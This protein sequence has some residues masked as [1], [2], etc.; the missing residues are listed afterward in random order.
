MDSKIWKLGAGAVDKAIQEVKSISEAIDDLAKVQDKAILATFGIQPTNESDSSESEGEDMPVE[1]HSELV[2]GGKNRVHLDDLV[3][4]MQ[5]SSFNWFQFHEKVVALMET[6]KEVSDITE[7]FYLNLAKFGFSQAEV[8]QISQSRQAFFAAENESHAYELDQT[9]RAVNGEIV[10]DDESDVDPQDFIRISDPLSE[11]A[12]AMVMKR[13]TAIQRRACRLKAKALEQKR[14][15]CR[16]VSKRTSKILATCSDIGERIEAY[17]QE[18]NVGADAWRRTGVLTFEG[19]I[20]LKEKVTYEGI[21]QHLQQVYQRHFSYGTVVELCVARNKRRRSAKRY[22]GMAKVT[23][24]RARKGFTLRY[25][26]DSHWSAAFYK[27]LNQLQYFDG[28][29]V[30]N[31]NRDDA[32]GFRLDT[33]TTCKQYA[34]PTI[35]GKDVLTTRTDYV[36]KYASV[37]QATSYNIFTKMKTTP[38]F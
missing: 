12:K 32:T 13:R 36:N 4:L 25:N 24:R 9:A 3:P 11:T 7:S 5:Q 2:G 1:D 16:K 21:R 23:T 6:E 14:F 30:T 31:I 35:Q 26:L 37:L 34:T 29:N 38:E 15:L 17:V 18:C 33:L 27:G 10:S 8:L 20:K 28:T 19:N 22:R